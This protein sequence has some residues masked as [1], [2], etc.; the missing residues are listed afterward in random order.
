MLLLEQKLPIM[1]VFTQTSGGPR[2]RHHLILNGVFGKIMVHANLLWS[3]KLYESI[4]ICDQVFS[5][6]FRYFLKLDN[7]IIHI[8]NSNISRIKVS[9]HQ[10]LFYFFQYD[11]I[12]K[13]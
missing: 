10:I 1:V 11:Q 4:N 2:M 12:F 13:I 9:F 6:F 3:F 8:G 7:L 5:F